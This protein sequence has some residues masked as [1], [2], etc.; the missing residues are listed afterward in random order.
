MEHWT[1]SNRCQLPAHWRSRLSVNYRPL[2]INFCRSSV[3]GRRSLAVLRDTSGCLEWTF[4]SN[5]QRTVR[6]LRSF[7]PSLLP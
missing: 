6:V 7:D 5:E 4:N 1:S 2:I 3:N